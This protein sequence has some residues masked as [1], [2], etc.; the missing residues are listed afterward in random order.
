M[1]KANTTAKAPHSAGG[2]EATWPRIGAHVSTAGH[3]DVAIEHAQ[4]IGA[5]AVQIFGAAPQQWR[6]KQHKAAETAA[7]RE[8]M[9]AAGIGPNFIH[10][11]YLIN[12]ASQDQGLVERGITSL[13]AD[14][15]LGSALGIAGVI[16]HVGSHRGAGFEPMLP[17][18]VHAMQ[19]ALEDAPEDVWLCIENNAGTGNSVGSTWEE[20]GAIM[21][22]VGSGRVKV[23][24][25]T[26]HAYASGYDL[27]DRAAFETAMERFDREIGFENLV[28]VHANDSKTPLGAGKDRHENIGAGTMGLGAFEHVLQHRAF[29][30]VAFLLEVPGFSGD[31]PDA[32]N[33]EILK[34]L[35]D[36]VVASA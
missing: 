31:G 9:A 1:G 11:V 18:I 32:E 22:G 26:C 33:V 23:C 28:A 27:S 6:R 4:A 36:R 17:Q 35:R 21:D 12:L 30:H 5:E 15:Q 24:L 10:G 7:F 16:F 20:I 29:R 2:D 19:T 14:L 13:K 34:G 25:D 3:I 8:G